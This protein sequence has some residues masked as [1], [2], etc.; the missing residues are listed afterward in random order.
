[1][2]PDVKDQLH[3]PTLEDMFQD[4]AEA[5]EQAQASLVLAAERMKWYFDLH[6]STVPFKV[7]DKV[8]IKGKDLRIRNASAKLAAKNY[9]PYEI[10]NKPGPVN[11]RLKLPGTMKVHPVFHA[12]KLI[13][14]Q[15]DTIADR[16]PPKPGPIEVEGHDEFEVEAILDS[17]IHRNK[18]QYFVK[19]KG[20][21]ESE[22]SWEPLHNLRNSRRLLD[23]FHVLHP[24]A[25]MPISLT[26]AKPI[27]LLYHR[28][29][30]EE[31]FEGPQP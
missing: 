16:N 7:G 23:E 9:G 14:Y 1:M 26:N 22:N 20:Y 2:A 25:P 3:H 30:R 5:R 27:Q 10:T 4:R 8:L 15:S 28:H 24:D 11:F 21:D 6:K 29:V 17:R 18:V 31:R 13:P 12:S 19:W